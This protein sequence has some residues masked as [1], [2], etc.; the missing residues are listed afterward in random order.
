MNTTESKQM[1]T[2]ESDQISFDLYDLAKNHKG[3]LITAIMPT[4]GVYPEA[5]KMKLLK[6][7]TESKRELQFLNNGVLSVLRTP[8]EILEAVHT[9]A[10]FKFSREQNYIADMFTGLYTMLT[11]GERF[12]GIEEIN[13]KSLDTGK[14]K[15]SAIRIITTVETLH[16]AALGPLLTENARSIHGAYDITHEAKKAIDPIINGKA[17]M[18]RATVTLKNVS[19]GDGT[20]SDL[21]ISGEPIH[22]HRHATSNMVAVDLD[23]YFAPVK[24]ENNRIVAG[25]QFLS[26]IAGLTSMLRLGKRYT[27]EGKC[28]GISSGTARKII[29]AIQM[30]MKFNSISGFGISKNTSGRI[31]ITVRRSELSNI[32]PEAVRDIGKPTERPY[33]KEVSNAVAKAG[34]YIHKAIEKTGIL[35]QLEAFNTP[36]YIPATDKGAEFPDNKGEPYKNIVYFKAD[37]LNK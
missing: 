37:P 14:E 7:A 21:W 17:P 1:N 29:L 35:D 26:S 27:D 10:L 28:L 4:A 34:Q 24:I 6:E 8:N 18:P 22:I 2:A 16:K 12:L 20:I 32:V 23:C 13:A 36:I 15:K 33:Y 5:Q 31:N 25:D 19:M 30:A 9:F 11:R 3:R